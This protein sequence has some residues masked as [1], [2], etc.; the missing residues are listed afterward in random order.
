[1]FDFVFNCQTIA[2]SFDKTPTTGTILYQLF[3]L[4]VT[5]MILLILSRF[6]KNILK[7]YF[8][9]VLGAFIF[10]FFTAPMWLNL[11]LGE[12]AY[13]Y[14]GV[15]WVLTIG[16]ASMTLASVVLVEVWFPKLKETIR[17][18]LSV[19]ILWPIMISVEKFVGFL[20]IRGYAPET[21]KAFDS[22]VIPSIDMSWLAILY[23]P[24]FFMLIIA[25]YKYFSFYL[26]KKPVIPMNKGKFGRNLIISFVGVLLFEL[27]V[28]AMVDNI[29]FPSWSY[30][31]RDIT[32]LLSG[33]WVL[34]ILIAA[35]LVDKYFINKNLI[36]KFI[37]YL[38]FSTIIIAP[39]ESWL[40]HSGHRVYLPSTV[41]NFSGFTVPI[42]NIP[43]EVIF[44]V[45]FYLAL[46][47]A[48]IRYWAIIIDNKL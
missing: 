29:G 17:Y 14:H 2:C 4:T 16:L 26:D 12:W 20:G 13:I 9:M 35:W 27:L 44:A 46:T 21:V 11:H 24:L 34:T 1:M 31:W 10:E 3:I 40:I 47:V 41:A 43:V 5:I 19:I 33:A 36:E 37:L 7:H 32:L 45:P 28:G 15:S 38:A 48:F 18:F 25:F 8:V 22:T 42:L 30:I 39:L 23:L 6:K